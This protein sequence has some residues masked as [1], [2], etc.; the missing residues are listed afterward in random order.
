[1][2]QQH[3]PLPWQIRAD[4]FAQLAA[5][6]KAGLPATQA[7]ALLKLPASLHQRVLNARKLLARGQPLAVIGRNSGLFTELEANLV[8]AAT[9]AGSPAPT[10]RRLADY[11]TRRAVQLKTMRSRMIYPAVLFIAG[12]FLNPLP[13]LVTGSLSLGRYILRCT[14]PLMA[15]AVLIYTGKRLMQD[16]EG[17]STPTQDAIGKLAMH[18]PLFGKMFIRSNIRDFFESLALMVEAGVPILDALPKAV[19]TV[20]LAPVREAFSHAR[21]DIMGGKTLA[22]A[23]SGISYLEKGQALA[24]INTGEG[25]GTL[26][27]MLFR[28]ADA[29]TQAIN[30]FNQ[31]VVEWAPRIVYALVAFWIARGILGGGHIGTELP[32][33]LQ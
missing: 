31:Q 29:E 11:Y 7:F 13:G 4:L 28:F 14:I 12:L 1:M 17:P 32:P 27:E 33:D 10:Y 24:L 19:A 30:L 15:I 23:L 20:K 25:S 21:A 18:M 22:E 6:E 2:P 5:M 9:N 16:Q 26:P 3:T 8:E